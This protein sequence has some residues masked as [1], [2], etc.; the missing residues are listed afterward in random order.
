MKTEKTVDVGP[1]FNRDGTVAV[2]AVKYPALHRSL[3]RG[4]DAQGESSRAGWAKVVELRRAGDADAA[5]RLVRKLLG[6]QGPPM[7]EETKEKL[8][9]YNEE[10]K[11]EIRERRQQQVAIRRRTLA[12][13]TTGT[14]R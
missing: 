4:L 5:D 8:R 12:L 14:R 7:S 6:V 1:L 3:Q 10:H 11:D 13:L 9:I 2:D